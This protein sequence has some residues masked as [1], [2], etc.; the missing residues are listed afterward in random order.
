MLKDSVIDCPVC[1]LRWYVGGVCVTH[2]RHFL[3]KK[4]WA[5][6]MGLQDLRNRLSGDNGKGS[7]K[8]VPKDEAFGKKLPSLWEFLTAPKYEDGADRETGTIL[9]FVEDGCVKGC[10]SNR[11]SGHVAFVSGSDWASMLAKA[12][13]GLASDSLDW[14]LSK[15]RQG[16]GQKR[17]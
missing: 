17:P 5:Y 4:G 9:V 15:G 1:S 2:L 7:C 16:K 6:A 8:E 14:R 10:L 11:D 13:K 12:E 3:P